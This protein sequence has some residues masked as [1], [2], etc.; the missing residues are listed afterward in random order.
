MTRYFLI[1]LSFLLVQLGYSQSGIVNGYASV[2]SINAPGTVIVVSNVDESGDTFEDGEKIIVMQMQDDVIGANTT[3]A[4]TFG[5]LSAIGKAGQYEIVVI[6]SHT[7]AAGLP[8][9][10]TLTSALQ[11]TY[12]IGS[13]SSVQIISFRRLGSPN[14]TTVGNITAK[15]WNGTTGGIVAIEVLGTLT[16][17]HNITADAAGFLG[18]ARS[19]NYYSGG[20][21]C[22]TVATTWIDNSNRRAEKGESIYK[23]TSANQ[24]YGKAKILNG[25]GGGVNIN[26]G[27]GGGGNVTA[28]GDGYMGW[29]CAAGSNS[30]GKGGISL[31]GSINGQRFFMGGGGGG[32]QQN[33]SV[34]SAGSDGGGIIIIHATT[35]TTTGACGGRVIS[36]NG[37]VPANSGNDGAGGGGA[38]GT[39][40]LYIQNYTI[41][42]GCLVTVS[43][44]GGRGGN[45][46]NGSVHA[47]GG[48]GGQGAV[49]YGWA[50]PVTNVTTQANN[51]VGGF[52]SSANGAATQGGSGAGVNGSGIFTN[53]LAP[54]PISLVSFIASKQNDEVLI[55]WVTATET[56]NQYFTVERSEN[57]QF[58][59]E[60]GNVNGAGNSVTQKSYF[61]TDLHPFTGINYYRLK[62]TDFDGKYSYSSIREVYFGE[63]IVE[64][65]VIPNPVSQVGNLKIIFS[66]HKSET[67]KFRILDQLGKSVLERSMELDENTMEYSFELSENETLIPGVY[68]FVVDGKELYKAAKIIVTE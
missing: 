29:S 62:Q 66:E 59:S 6:S 20:T 17:A 13:N 61:M 54:L 10:I 26:A 31:A 57:G 46:A 32:G 30:G 16:L 64:F 67:V 9:N 39:V 44:N 51:G 33:N 47:G 55:N 24:R 2:T 37:G 50:Q 35:L 41:A 63:R 23:R 56:N 21:T 5:D 36:A 3:N 68:Y 48:G 27:G 60:I 40:S 45:V 8:V 15:D 12:N 53:A 7:E 22:D 38:G 19:A 18:G 52:S 25:G 42:G 65:N 43:A 34:G 14:F 28:G 11:N 49:I 4:S 1:S 58:F